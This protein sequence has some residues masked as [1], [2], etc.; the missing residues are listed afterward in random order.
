MVSPP[1]NMHFIIYNALLC[2]G[3]KKRACV[4]VDMRGWVGGQTVYIS[5]V[6]MYRNHLGIWVI[7]CA[8]R[9]FG[10]GSRISVLGIYEGCGFYVLGW[11]KFQMKNVSLI[12]L[13][14]V[15]LNIFL[16]F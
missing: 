11:K 13:L 14:L 2:C 8:L 9:V 7:L 6:Y 1:P 10:V 3:E 16:W 4:D 5:N 15:V 12:F